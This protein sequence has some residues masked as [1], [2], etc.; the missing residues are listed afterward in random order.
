MEARLCWRIPTQPIRTRSAWLFCSM[1][2]VYCR[3]RHSR[4]CPVADKVFFARPLARAIWFRLAEGN[5]M[6]RSRG[7]L[8]A[9]FVGHLA[10][11]GWIPAALA[12]AVLLAFA[13]LVYAGDQRE[14]SFAVH[15]D[16][17]LP[18]RTTVP[19]FR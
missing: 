8:A 14:E 1:R 15:H 12:G 10:A 17:L 9:E 3:E 6:R 4:K 19:I 7:A 18:V 11:L 13:P 2:S 5:V 16:M